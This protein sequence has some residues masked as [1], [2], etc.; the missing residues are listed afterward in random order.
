MNLFGS[1]DGSHA[2]GRKDGWLVL[3][4]CPRALDP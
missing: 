2:A 1:V 3:S 4:V